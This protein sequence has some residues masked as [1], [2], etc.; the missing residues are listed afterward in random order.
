MSYNPSNSP[1]QPTLFG[2]VSLWT[3]PQFLA[4]K[5]RHL[6]ANKQREP[7]QISE[8]RHSL[9]QDAQVISMPGISILEQA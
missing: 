6:A 8:R 5:E 7:W 4:S 9:K 2:P 1:N 3:Y